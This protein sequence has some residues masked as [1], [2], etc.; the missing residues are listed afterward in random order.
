MI[1]LLPPEQKEQ[2]RYGII[3]VRLRRYALL[4]IFVVLAL[5]G[6]YIGIQKFASKQISGI[7]NLLLDKKDDISKFKDVEKQAEKLQNDITI[8]SNLLSQ[9]TAFSQILSDIASVLPTNSYITSIGLSTDTTKPVR[10][11]VVTDSLEGAGIVRNSLLTSERIDAVDIQN[12][13]PS[14]DLGG[15]TVN[16]ILAFKKGAI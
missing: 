13:S 12:I 7:E 14:N 5:T 10:L 6:I 15:F 1:N 3:N 9:Q 8:V 2:V 11:V 4:L 16:I